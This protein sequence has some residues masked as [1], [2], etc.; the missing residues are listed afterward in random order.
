[1]DIKGT[2]FTIVTQIFLLVF[3]LSASKPVKADDKTFVRKLC[4]QTLEP[5]TTYAHQC[6]DHLYQNTAAVRLKTTYRVC[7]DTMLSASNT[8]W[9]GLTKMEV[10]DYKNAHVSA[11]MAHLDLLRCVFAFRK[12]AN[13]PVPAELLSYMVQTK[14]LFDAAQFM[15]LLLD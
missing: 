14:R 3:L 10:S 8:L 2:T 13:V 1:M 15:F 9:D 4:D 7:R 12:Y 5:D 6:A 11:R